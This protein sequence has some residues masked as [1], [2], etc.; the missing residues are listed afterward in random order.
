LAWETHVPAK[1]LRPSLKEV[2]SV[3]VRMQESLEMG[4]RAAHLQT[5]Q[6]SCDLQAVSGPAVSLVNLGH[7]LGLAALQ[8]Q[9]SAVRWSGIGIIE[10]CL[11]SGLV[12]SVSSV[13]GHQL[14]S[15]F[16]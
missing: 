14:S 6:S 10:F 7:S 16:T 12:E 15:H 3:N 2:V 11:P 13:L 8:T 5:R 4:A 1:F 9:R